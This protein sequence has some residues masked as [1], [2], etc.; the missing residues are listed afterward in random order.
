MATWRELSEAEPELA[1]RVQALFD[2]ARHKTIATLRKDGSP[3]ISGIETT[4]VLGELWFGSMW[5]AVKALDLLRDPR[6]A[7]H[8]PTGDAD[9]ASWPGDAKISG[10]IEEIIDPARV[11]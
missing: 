3:R 5:R 4:F 9:P 10:R 7:L 11:A 2:A 6:F 8:S 1:S